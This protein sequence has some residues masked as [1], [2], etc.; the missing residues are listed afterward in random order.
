VVVRSHRHRNSEIRLPAKWGYAIAFVTP[1]WQLKTPFVFR[2][3]GGRTSTPQI[4]GSIIRLGDEELH[5]RHFVQDIGR[6]RV[7]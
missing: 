2:I 7:E 6:G 3:P 4:G 5:T 1:A